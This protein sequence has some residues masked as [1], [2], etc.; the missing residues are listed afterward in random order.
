MIVAQKAIA[1]FTSSLAVSKDYCQL[2]ELLSPMHCRWD[3]NE[4]A[5]DLVGA[6]LACDHVRAGMQHNSG[7]QV[8][9]DQA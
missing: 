5:E 1:V 2:S 8:L 9:A 4:D 7:W 6:H 3:T